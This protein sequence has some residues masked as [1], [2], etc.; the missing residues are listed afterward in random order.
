MNF[1]DRIK[2]EMS[3]GIVRAILEDAG[4]R[5]IDSGIEKVLRE[6]SCMPKETY[7]KLGF[8]EAI[9][10]LPD[11]TVMDKDQTFKVLVD[12]KYRKEWDFKLLDDVYEQVKLYSS[13][14][15]VVINACPPRLKEDQKLYPSGHIRCIDLT[16][17]DR[18]DYMVKITHPDKSEEWV[19]VETVKKWPSFWWST[20]AMSN[21]FKAIPEKDNESSLRAAI[22]AISGIIKEKESAELSLST[23]GR[24]TVPLTDWPP[25][26]D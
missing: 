8:P 18:G 23:S 16:I 13:L 9:R 24:T 2:K 5:V 20:Q 19:K 6:I 3:E 25:T 12:V 22:D 7:I 17:N 15:L 10:L 4:Y 14:T 26:I 1:I 21:K 11:L